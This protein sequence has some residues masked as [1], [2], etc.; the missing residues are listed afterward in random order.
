M[1]DALLRFHGLGGRAVVGPGVQVSAVLGEVRA[2]DLEPYAVPLAEE[3]ARGADCH[4][5]LVYLSLF[6]Q[7]GPLQ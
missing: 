6:K 3:D 2:S 5:E 1:V 7:S 4:L